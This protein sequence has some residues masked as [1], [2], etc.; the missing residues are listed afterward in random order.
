VIL[1]QWFAEKYHLPASHPLFQGRSLAEHL[2]EFMRDK[3]DDRD[4]LQEQM[5][6]AH[7]TPLDRTKII[8]QIE[9]IDAF[10]GAAEK[11]GS[12]DP[13][14]DLWEAQLEAGEEPDL[15]MT[16]EDLRRG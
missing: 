12:G 8:E 9:G 3:M 5:G 11:V 7:L 1:E 13:L 2:E 16:M 10:L 6:Q 15:D 14:A 4:A